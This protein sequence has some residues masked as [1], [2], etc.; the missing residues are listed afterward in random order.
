MNIIDNKLKIYKISLYLLGKSIFKRCKDLKVGSSFFYDFCISKNPSR[1]F[2]LKYC[3]G[4]TVEKIAE[5]LNYDMRSVYKQIDN[6]MLSFGVWLSN[7][8]PEA[9]AFE[10][11]RNRIEIAISSEFSKRKI[12]T[13]DSKAW[14]QLRSDFLRALV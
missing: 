1:S 7:D 11:I 14:L 5:Q 10:S 13:A 9:E 6:D 12:A 8:C 4:L 3:E 2:R